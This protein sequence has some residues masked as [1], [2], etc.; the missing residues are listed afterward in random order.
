M[1]LDIIK[2][3]SQSDAIKYQVI[4]AIF[5]YLTKN[6]LTWTPENLKNFEKEDITNIARMLNTALTED[7]ISFIQKD[8]LE[9]LIPTLRKVVK[10]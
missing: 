6:D 1:N 8:I 3:Q 9:N 4:G 7:E 5:C 10:G 2:R